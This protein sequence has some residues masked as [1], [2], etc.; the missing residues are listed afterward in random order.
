MFVSGI[1]GTSQDAAESEDAEQTVALDL[2]PFMIVN[3]GLHQWQENEHRKHATCTQTHALADRIR[4]PPLRPEVRD[5]GDAWAPLISARPRS[6]PLRSA[7]RRLACLKFA[8]RRSAPRRQ[9]PRRSLPRKLASRRSAPARSVPRKSA[10]AMSAPLRSAPSRC[11][12]NMSDPAREMPDASIPIRSACCSC[13]PSSRAACNDAC[14]KSAFRRSAPRRSQWSNRRGPLTDMSQL[15]TF[16]GAC[17]LAVVADAIHAMAPR[18]AR[19][20]APNDHGPTARPMRAI[21]GG[22]GD[23]ATV[24]LYHA[25][26]NRQSMTRSS[27]SGLRS[28]CLTSWLGLG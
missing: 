21:R 3:V 12:P 5:L 20:A 18:T 8:P 24:R 27:A 25:N 7:W 4:W 15:G 22:V 1:V 11:A 6:A 19:T 28:V 14:R 13:A 9:A 17:S 23:G 16:A 2:L 26:L 10:P